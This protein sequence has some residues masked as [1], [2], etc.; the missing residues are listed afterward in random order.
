MDKWKIA[1]WTCFTILMV[2]IAFSLYAI[3]DQGV[4][5]TYMKD[6]FSKTEKDLGDLTRIINQ[7]DLTKKEIRE[8]LK[9]NLLFEYMEFSGDTI[10]LN[11][12]SLIFKNDKLVEVSSSK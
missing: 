9:K 2:T 10:S 4:T 7:T 8:A 1:F 12:V 11:T 3:V 5:L 6:G